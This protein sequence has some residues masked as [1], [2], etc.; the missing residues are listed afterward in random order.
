MSEHVQ[1]IGSALI[2]R[3]AASSGEAIRVARLAAGM[4]QWDLASALGV[5]QPLVSKMESGACGVGLDRMCQVMKVFGVTGLLIHP[6]TQ[7]VEFV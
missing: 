7:E 3:V 2:G 6:R 1:S 4:S 5:R